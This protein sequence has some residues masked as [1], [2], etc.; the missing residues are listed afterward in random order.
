[1]LVNLCLLQNTHVCDWLWLGNFDASKYRRIFSRFP[2]GDCKPIVSHWFASIFV[3]TVE[4]HFCER[5]RGTSLAC[6]RNCSFMRRSERR[7]LE[8]A[9]C[10]SERDAKKREKRERE[11]NFASLVERVDSSK[12]VRDDALITRGP[13]N[14]GRESHSLHAWSTL[15]CILQTFPTFVA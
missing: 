14:R 5:S 12:G 1:M 10:Q 15:S 6:S 9:W 7:L 13:M 4:F 11:R 3:R 8:T 2:G